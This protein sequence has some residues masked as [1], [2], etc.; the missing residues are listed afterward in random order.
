MQWVNNLKTGIKLS[1]AFSVMVLLMLI[2]AVIGFASTNNINNNLNTMYHDRTLPIQEVGKASTA[3]S[4]LQ[5]DLFR[6]VILPDERPRTKEAILADQETIKNQMD[7]YRAMQPT[8]DEL[9]AL[10]EFDRTYSIYQQAVQQAVSDTDAGKQDLVIKSFLEGGALTNARQ[11]VDAQMGKIIDI[12]S[13]ISEE[14]DTQG[15]DTFTFSRFLLIGVPFFAILIVI[16]FGTAITS[17]ITAPL[18]FVA[19]ELQNISNG[20]LN[21]DV[22]QKKRVSIAQRKDELG[23]V[24]QGLAAVEIYLQEMA[25]AAHRI[26]Q[27]DLTLSIDPKSEKDELGNAFVLMID[28]LRKTV[29]QVADSSRR[30]NKASR[31]MATSVEQA[32]Q[33][34]GQIS[35]TIE[36][37]TQS[38]HD[39]TQEVTKTSFSVAQMSQVIDGVAKGAQEQSMAITRVSETSAHINTSI[40]QVAGNA[41]TVT[42]DS[43][44]AAEIA[45]NGSLTVKATLLAM[46]SI[47]TRVGLSAQKVQ[48]M[49]LRSNEIGAIVETIDDIAS[50]TNLL[51]LNAAI[52]AARAGEH[53][54]GF[55]VVADEVRK[56]AE[57]SSIATKEIG[58]LISGIQTTVNEAVKAMSEGSK[59]VETGLERANEAGQALKAI[60][61]ASEAVNK[62]AQL[63]AHASQ[64]MATAAGD[65]MAAVDS[66][67]AVIEENTAA[68]EQMAANS[69]EVTRAM[70][71]ITSVSEENSA[72]V[73]LVSA[74]TVD[75]FAQVEEVSASV[76]S[77]TTLAQNLAQ[78][79]AQFKLLE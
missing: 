16:G 51:A 64:G 11:E 61:E 1:G 21:R 53:G 31:R 75:L 60:L 40:Q 48:E 74:S 36:K 66:V 79:V 70:E 47:K 7:Q 12:N 62:Q 65:M 56:L 23:T 25:Q 59:E 24:V 77:L 29:K 30:L 58:K 55:A 72:A 39:Q 49:G 8:K 57:R 6:Y 5:A 22:D 78:V 13:N 19:R 76:Q 10:A 46:E 63:A 35:T 20:N 18:A 3:L 44:I 52:E 14:I 33:A 9:T 17:S 73:E 27:N 26:T 43:A 41:E 15:N 42:N 28:S 45:R 67:S 2:I 71:T 38:I 32:G 68:T 54:K 50:Q 34:T 69:N 4:K 37:I